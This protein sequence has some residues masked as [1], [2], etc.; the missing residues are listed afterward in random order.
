[1]T[2]LDE[3]DPQKDG[4]RSYLTAIAAKK[5]RGDNYYLKDKIAS[6]ELP[7]PARELHP[8]A[9]VHHMKK[10]R[11]VK[12][13]REDAAWWATAAGVKRIKPQPLAVEL[14]FLPPDNHRRDV[15]GLISSMKA[16]L[17]GIASVLR[18]DDHLFEPVTGKM[19]PVK[20]GG[21]V[22]IEIVGK[23]GL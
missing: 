20:D 6:V 13:A 3:Y 2:S 11:I 21:A 22:R 15:D 19:G 4:A 7:W 17:D 5:A 10:A 9:R 18:I 16:A 14:T 1:M 12:Q 23:G 8:N